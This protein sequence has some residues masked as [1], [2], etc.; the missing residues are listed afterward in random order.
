M[1]LKI[2]IAVVGAMLLAAVGCLKPLPT[3]GP[4]PSPSP[5]P[6][7]DP[8]STPV[9]IVVLWESAQDHTREELV[10]L[11]ST[12]LAIA[13]DDRSNGQWRR[14]DVSSVRNGIEEETAEW[15][16]LWKSLTNTIRDTNLRLPV[17]ITVGG[18]T[19]V[20]PWPKSVEEAIAIVEQSR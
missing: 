16:A 6:V 13:L 1:R 8:I 17:L 4:S 14:W 7:I 19:N 3:P 20:H 10:V 18:K 2:L 9:R 5:P 11:N 12:K 15:Q